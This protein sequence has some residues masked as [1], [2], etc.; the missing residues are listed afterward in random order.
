MQGELSGQVALITGST[1]GV[2]KAIAL[3][4]ARHGAGIILNGRHADKASP[5]LA[6]LGKLG[7]QAIFEP[8]DITS[9]DSL[10]EM[11]RRAVERMGSIDILVASGGAKS[12][13]MPNFFHDTDPAQYMD[14]ALSQWFSRLY[15]TR[16][17]LDQMIAQKKGK[18][19]LI[20][21]DAGRWPTPGESVIGGAGAAVVMATKALA[22]EFGRWQIRVNAIGMTVIRDSPAAEMALDS[23][24]AK[25]FQ[26]AL[27]R[28][29]FPTVTDDIAD[30]ALFLASPAG[31]HITGQILSVNGGLCFPG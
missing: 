14:I 31:D 29:I 23:P 25:I 24:A 4:L 3:K 17:V 20:T 11:A 1:D 6:E 19:I 12:L 30:A 21:T 13:L 15:A 7:T 27:K 8:A 5:V 28:Q 9:Y 2:G 22:A 10:K 26:K 16:A 18:I